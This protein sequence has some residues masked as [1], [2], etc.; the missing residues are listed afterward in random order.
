MY[1]THDSKS[2]CTEFI[3]LPVSLH[4][5]YRIDVTFVERKASVLGS[6]AHPAVVARLGVRTLAGVG[7]EVGSGEGKDRSTGIIVRNE[8]IRGGRG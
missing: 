3:D 2:L 5:V 1:L 8:M 6:A 4:A 7:T